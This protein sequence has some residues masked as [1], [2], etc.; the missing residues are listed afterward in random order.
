MTRLE[1]TLKASA[2]AEISESIC[3]WTGCTDSNS[4]QTSRE[5]VWIR[6][7]FLF[8]TNRLRRSFEMYSIAIHQCFWILSS[9]MPPAAPHQHSLWGPNFRA[10]RMARF[11]AWAQS[12]G[13]MEPRFWQDADICRQR[14]LLDSF[15]LTFPRGMGLTLG[16]RPRLEVDSLSIDAFRSAC[17]ADC[18]GLCVANSKCWSASPKGISGAVIISCSPISMARLRYSP[19]QFFSCV[20]VVFLKLTFLGCSLLPCSASFLT[21]ECSKWSEEDPTPSS[22][23]SCFPASYDGWRVESPFDYRDSAVCILRVLC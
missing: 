11:A 18:D 13:P 10:S 12:P 23:N 19:K 9:Q 7:D 5:A 2:F 15:M 3:H 6:L 21:G 22:R 20:C 8:Q 1:D 4:W 14:W 17:A 16:L